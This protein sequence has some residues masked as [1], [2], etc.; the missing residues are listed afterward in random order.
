MPKKN[1]KKS[2]KVV[3]VSGGFD[4]VHVGHLRL[5]Q[6][7]K[8]LGDELVVVVNN[9][10]WKNAKHRYIFMRDHDR[11]EIIEALACVDKVLLTSHKNP[12]T[13]KDMSVSRELRKIRP[14]I[15][16]NGADRN[17]HDAQD[18]NSSL[19]Y[20]VQTCAELGITTVFN[21]GKGGKIRSSSGLLKD[22]AQKTKNKVSKKSKSNKK[23]KL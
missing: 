11:K 13:P 5:F 22:Y 17:E 12:Q 4:P 19:Y 23:Q 6:Q 3:M 18:P 21:V 14:D 7:A 2:K 1:L 16:A 20:D 15:F 8:E 9:D 10:S